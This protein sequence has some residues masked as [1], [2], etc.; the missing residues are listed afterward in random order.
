MA[1]KGN[2][3]FVLVIC[4]LGM[5]TKLALNKEMIKKEKINV[6][7]VRSQIALFARAL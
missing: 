3:H 7:L 1:D 4:F 6:L 2:L 5:I